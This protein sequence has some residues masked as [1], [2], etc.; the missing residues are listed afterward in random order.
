MRQADESL[1]EIVRRVPLLAG[2]SAADVSSLAHLATRRV[3]RHGRRIFREGDAGDALYILTRGSVFITLLSNEGSESILA[4]LRAGDCLGELA[5]LDGFERSATARVA[6]D[7]EALVVTREDFQSWLAERPS[8]SAALLRT[9]SMRIRRMNTALADRNALD[10]W[11]RLS[12]QLLLLLD[13]QSDLVGGAADRLRIT[14]QELADML[15]VTREAVNKT[16]RQFADEGWIEIRRGT[17]TIRDA[18]AL[19]QQL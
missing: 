5:L 13:D 2:L 4:V 8:A 1:A 12:K 15:G 14:Q 6:D 7:V 16:L 9:L 18:S 3:F 19:A 11:Q 10:L 17:I